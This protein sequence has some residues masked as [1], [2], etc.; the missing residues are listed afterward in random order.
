[1]PAYDDADQRS[2]SDVAGVHHGRR[3]GQRVQQAK[4]VQREPGVGGDAS[5][6]DKALTDEIRRGATCPVAGSCGTEREYLYIIMDWYCPARAPFGIGR[7]K[8]YIG[9][10]Q[11]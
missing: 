7:H 1:M 2:S 10:R 9:S 4:V 8:M 3:N 11:A 5:S 6:G